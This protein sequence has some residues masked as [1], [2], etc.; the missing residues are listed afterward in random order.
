[1]KYRPGRVHVMSLV[2]LA[3]VGI[4]LLFLAERSKSPAMQRYFSDK[5]AAA[6]RTQAALEIA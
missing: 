3:A 2:A 4:V 1:M 5:I 6:T